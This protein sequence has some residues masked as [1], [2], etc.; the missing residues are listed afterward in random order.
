M[1]SDISAGVNCAFPGIPDFKPVIRSGNHEF[2]CPTVAQTKQNFEF[3]PFIQGSYSSV[4]D[5]IEVGRKL[6][7][8]LETLS[9]M[10]REAP[11][12]ILLA[13]FFLG[14]ALAKRRW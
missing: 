14:R 10:T 7:N 13:A 1:L 9:K 2:S 4:S 6:G 5:A 11:L 8:A 3:A 12:G